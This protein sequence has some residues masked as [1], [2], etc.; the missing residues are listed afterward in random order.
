MPNPGTLADVNEMN[1]GMQLIDQKVV[2][3]GAF[4]GAL[5]GHIKALFYRYQSVAGYDYISD[6]LIAP[7]SAAAQTVPGDSGTV[8]HLVLP[9][10][11]DPKIDRQCPLAIEWGGQGLFNGSET[12]NFALATIL[13]HV[14]HELKLELVTRHNTGARPFWGATGHYSIARYAIEMVESVKLKKLL[15]ANAARISFER[16]DLESGDINKK[17]S[18]DSFVPLADVPDIVWKKPVSN[19]LGGRDNGSAKP[20]HPTHYADVDQPGV[21]DTPSLLALCE[22]DSSNVEVEVWRKFY[23]SLGHTKQSSRGLLP[24]RVWQFFNEM[25]QFAS[26]GDVTS[27]VAAAG[28]LAHYVGDACQP[29]HG[30]VLSNGYQD[31]AEEQL[32]STGKKKLVWPAQ[33]VHSAYEDKMIDDHTTAL[34]DGIEALTKPSKKWPKIASGH[35]AAVATVSLMAEAQR[36]LPPAAICDEYIRLGGGKSR[37]T[38]EGL[39]KQFDKA[40]IQTMYNGA[41]V[42]ALVWNAAWTAGNG[43]Q[44]PMA[45]LKA[46]GEAAFEKLYRDA[47]FVES[48]DLDAIASKLV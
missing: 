8:W 40:T 35:D 28:I 38:S 33:G 26:D 41:S 1:L 19:G 25:R 12:R 9:D 46:I 39:W 18:A 48:L 30:S 5:S 34:F 10:P 4:S 31:Q 16:A 43:E 21:D 11:V 44:L 20:E 42:L 37:A 3:Y 6:L 27:F 29:L 7:E 32:T 24:F 22:S 13:S 17:L 47:G 2:A 14:L 45:K 23:D 36:L 15:V